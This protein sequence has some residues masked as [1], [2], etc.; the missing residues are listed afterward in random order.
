MPPRYTL[1]Q[2]STRLVELAEL[3][4]DM[5]DD[6]V[7]EAIGIFPVFF[8]QV[9]VDHGF[10]DSQAKALATK[11]RD[12]GR[13]SAPWKPTSSKVPGRPQD[14]AD[15]NRIRRWDL[16]ADHKQYASE[17]DASLV[18]IRYYLQALSFDD[19]PIVPHPSFSTAWS[20]LVEH[21][22]APGEYLEPIQL[23]PI[24]LREVLSNPRIIT[25]GHIVPL[26][27]EG[28][29]EPPNTSLI[30]SRS[31][32]MQGNMTLNEYLLLSDEIVQ[33]HRE[34]GTID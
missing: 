24:S 28:R 27:R 29:H 25:S 5:S 22:V 3:G 9:L 31:N 2:A 32:Q 18:E 23:L 11:F 1:T 12:A 17:R 33:R 26:D 13:R 15:G 8:R 30:F 21:K 19:A 20:W 16:P 14:G 6:Q 10:L 34:R 7:R 4:P